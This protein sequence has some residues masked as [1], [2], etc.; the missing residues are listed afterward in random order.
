MYTEDAKKACDEYFIPKAY[1]KSQQ[2]LYDVLL[3]VCQV[4]LLRMYVS[5]GK[6]KITRGI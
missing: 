3:K 2:T 1:I 4:G 5:L 6:L